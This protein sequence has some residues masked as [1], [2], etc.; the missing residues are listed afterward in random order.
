MVTN[1]VLHWASTSYVFQSSGQD[2]A[3][4]ELVIGEYWVSVLGEGDIVRYHERFALADGTFLQETIYANGL[5]T[6]ILSPAFRTNLSGDCVAEGVSAT[7]PSGIVPPFAANP[8]TLAR[9]GFVPSGGLTR[10]VPVTPVLPAVQPLERYAVGNSVQGWERRETVGAGNTMFR[11][12]EI[13]TVGRVVAAEGRLIDATGSVVEETRQVFGTLE[14][15]DPSSIPD[16]V[17]TIS[18]EAQE[19]CDA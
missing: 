17:F 5:T 18:D 15:Y 12:L 14:I 9:L 16:S 3:N 13:D 2:P 19:A 11:R 8:A 7:P 4:G 1:K 10:D 6:T